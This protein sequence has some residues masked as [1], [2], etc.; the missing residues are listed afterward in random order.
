[1]V[2]VTI[3]I[4]VTVNTMRRR[5][6][7]LHKSAQVGVQSV[8][9]VYSDK[10]VPVNDVAAKTY[11][12]KEHVEPG[13]KVVLAA[14]TRPTENGVY[15][16]RNDKLTR[17][18]E[19]HDNEM[20]GTMVYDQ[21]TG[22][23]WVTRR[24]G[25]DRIYVPAM[26][27][28]FG[29]PPKNKDAVLLLSRTDPLKTRWVPMDTVRIPNIPSVTSDFRLHD[30]NKDASKVEIPRVFHF[31]YG[32]WDDTE[33]PQS[34]KENIGRWT[35]ANTYYRTEVWNKDRLE[36]LIDEKY[37]HLHDVYHSLA[38][39]VQR[40]DFGRYL[41]VYDQGG[42]YFDL[43]AVSGRKNLGDLMVEHLNPRLVLFTEL[44]MSE[45][46]AQQVGQHEPIR[47]GVPEDSGPR[48]ANYAFGACKKHPFMSQLLET[49]TRRIVKNPTI[50]RDYDV[51]YTTGPDCLTHAYYKFQEEHPDMAVV[52]Y[53]SSRDYVSHGET[54]TW[55]DQKDL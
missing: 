28:F 9:H 46:T 17:V 40:A 34:F 18:N 39:N 44:I 6:A 48:M 10:E 52:N 26:E 23:S 32:L 38:R 14:Q 55:R 8:S 45:E 37:P 16:Y 53:E 1:M 31:M 7:A 13:Q 30:V 50:H 21:S 54:G 12:A 42:W 41:I 27:H 15:E 29:E 35:E 4:L 11:L 2:S 20:N 25:E 5:Q 49:S 24:S 19:A 47:N 33:M 36:N 22:T 51:L 3:A 43:D